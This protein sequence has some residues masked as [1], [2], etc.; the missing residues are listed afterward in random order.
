MFRSTSP[1]V[2]LE[3]LFPEAPERFFTGVPVFLGLIRADAP[4]AAYQTPT[5]V[6]SETHF[7]EN[8]PGQPVESYL[9]EAVRGFFQS[10][11]RMCY[12]LPLRAITE[13]DLTIALRLLETFQAFDLLCAPDLMTLYREQDPNV[14]DQIIRLQLQLSQHCLQMND[15]FAI[16]DGLPDRTLQSLYEQRR[17]LMFA[18]GRNCALYYPWVLVRETAPGRFIPPCGHIAGIY[19]LTDYKKGVHKAPANEILPG[20]YD[21]TH[22][23]SNREQGQ[24]NDGG[25]N[26]I[27]A[28]RGYGI[29]IWGAKTLS[30]RPE[31]QYVNTRRLFFKIR[32]WLEHYTF[33]LV[34]EPNT[35]QMWLSI[36]N[37]LTVYL[38]TLVETGEITQY[39]VK[40]N[41]ETNPPADRERGIIRTEIGIAPT[42]PTEFIVIRVMHGEYGLVIL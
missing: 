9:T 2:Y 34:F 23:L 33:R 26:C 20:V 11:G 17:T 7:A 10:G 5:L 29:R 4:D 6:I 31:W 30:N 16:L 13:H 36:E 38:G 37:N 15:R 19:T 39:Y 24:L 25:V 14:I 12:I 1:G 22:H 27:R 18:D 42:I 21:L 28:L 3:D 40:C 8:F 35:E 41:A 32:R